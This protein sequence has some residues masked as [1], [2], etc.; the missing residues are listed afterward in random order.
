[1]TGQMIADIITFQLGSKMRSRSL[2]DNTGLAKVEVQCPAET[3]VVNQSLFLRINN[4]AE[5]GHLR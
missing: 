1:M 4:F 3:F 2:A 5:N